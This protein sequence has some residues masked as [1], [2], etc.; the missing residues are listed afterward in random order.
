[1]VFINRKMEPEGT[2]LVEGVHKIIQ[3][4]TIEIYPNVLLIALGQVGKYQ[5]DKYSLK[6]YNTDENSGL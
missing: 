3:I 5:Y 4:I 6:T 1:M 2:I